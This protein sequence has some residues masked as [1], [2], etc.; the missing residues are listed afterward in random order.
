M[1]P[2]QEM[3]SVVISW[4]FQC[5][6]GCLWHVISLLQVARADASR[7]QSQ[8]SVAVALQRH[9]C[10]SA[11]H[12]A[13]S[14]LCLLSLL[15]AALC[16]H[17]HASASLYMFRIWDLEDFENNTM[18]I[19]KIIEDHWA[20]QRFKDLCH[21]SHF[22]KVEKLPSGFIPGTFQHF[23]DEERVK[24]FAHF[25]LRLGP[26]WFLFSS[27]DGGK[28]LG[29][30]KPICICNLFYFLFGDFVLCFWM[31]LVCGFI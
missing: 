22:A 16:F 7:E 6:F 30:C 24:Q 29:K 26:R 5:D 20:R 14:A 28:M 23:Q 19:M 12:R 10:T 15:S 1:Q 4:W 13:A 21:L 9:R 11:L 31:K 8:N 27:M 17:S 18:K 2:R 3:W 25:G